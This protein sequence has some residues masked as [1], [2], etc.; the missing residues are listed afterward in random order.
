MFIQREKITEKSV[1]WNV[2]LQKLH[3]W[4]KTKFCDVGLLSL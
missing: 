4:L 2:K 1:F 3:A